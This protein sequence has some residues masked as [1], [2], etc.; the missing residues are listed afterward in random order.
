MNVQLLS[1]GLL[2]TVFFSTK[3]ERTRQ[4]CYICTTSIYYCD[5]NVTH[6]PANL[7]KHTF[8]LSV[9]L[10]I[11]VFFF[12]HY[13]VLEENDLIHPDQNNLDYLHTQHNGE[14]YSLP[15]EP[16][17]KLRYSDV[18]FMSKAT[19]CAACDT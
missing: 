16:L 12:L 2:A 15:Q 17:G 8:T 18:P 10:D 1:H 7:L 4:Y 3:C 14:K 5:P 11:I 9:H 13:E 6:W 19:L